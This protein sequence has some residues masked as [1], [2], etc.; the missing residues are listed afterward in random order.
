[1]PA[2]ASIADADADHRSGEAGRRAGLNL[3]GSDISN[4]RLAMMGSLPNV[5]DLVSVLEGA[6]R[7]EA[8]RSAG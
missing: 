7:T 6:S 4:L 2:V 8:P 1:V 3:S 5:A